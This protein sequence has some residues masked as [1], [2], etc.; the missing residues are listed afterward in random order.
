MTAPEV[1]LIA[2]TRPEAVKLAPVAKRMRERGRLKPLVVASGQHPSMAAQALAAFDMA[3]DRALPLNRSTGTQP[4]L[5]AGLVRRLDEHLAAHDPAA[6]VVQGDTTT[7]LAGAL[8]AF[9]RRI[10]VVH[11]EAGL[12]TG[13]LAV[14]FPEEANRRMVAQLAD[15]HLAPTTQGAANLLGEGIPPGRIVLTGNTVVDAVL[16]IAG[17]YLD[18]PLA[19][20]RLAVAAANRL[21]LLTAHRR[22]SWGDPLDRVLSA[23]RS[24]LEA[25]P[26]VWVAVPTHPNPDVRAQVSRGLQDVDRAVVTDPLPYPD[27]VS[28]LSKSYLVLTDS[29]G[30]QEEAPTFGV[31]VL[32]LRDATERI[33]SL[34]A[35]CA[36]LVGTDPALVAS[37]AA[38][39]LDDPTQR[40]AMTAAGNPYGDGRAA[41]RTEQ[42]VAFLLGL[43]PRPE[44]L[45]PVSQSAAPSMQICGD[46][47][48]DDAWSSL[49]NG[50]VALG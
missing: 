37:E 9:W 47:G 27:L 5:L 19:D 48:D 8:A 24:V 41:E 33:E 44:P 1:H 49:D 14:P 42:A 36:R 18:R 30:I 16:D 7:T 3:P 25:Y 17:R 43:A 39:L 50:G 6:V 13:D 22:E 46:D 45:P 29:G 4:E 2:G 31:P 20:D 35:G 10:P 15:L 38:R 12:R 26:D 21:I 34:E 23:V 40:D 28:I 32:V 11:L